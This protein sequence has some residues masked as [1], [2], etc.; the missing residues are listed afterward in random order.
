[1]PV[2][3]FAGLECDADTIRGYGARRAGRH[4]RRAWKACW[5]RS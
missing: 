1:L 2:D 4:R 5:P 3:E